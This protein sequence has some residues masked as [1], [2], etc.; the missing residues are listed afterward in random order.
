MTDAQQSDSFPRGDQ[1]GKTRTWWHPLLV[2]MLDYALGSAFTVE[3]EVSVGKIPLRVDILLV[4]REGGQLSEAKRQEL[5]ALVP[6]LNRFTLIE[7]K[8]PTD[9]MERGDFSQLVG[10]SF[11][12]LSQ[13]TEAVPHEDVSLVVLAPT[14]TGPLRDEL[15]LLSCEVREHEPGILQVVGL[16]FLTWLVETDLMAKRGQPI[17]SLVSRVF[18]KDRERIIEELVHTGHETLLRYMVQQIEQFGSKEGFAMQ[19]GVSDDL[20]QMQELGEELLTKILERVPAE[21]RLRGL[22]PEELLASLTE[23]QAARLRELLVRE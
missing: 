21:R 14:V 8:G 9:G 16:P 11:L 15:R 6:L 4:R 17:L 23:E 1:P 20:Q 3:E 12:W 2:R 13:Q 18:L 10:C 22:S 19:H 7:F 5:S